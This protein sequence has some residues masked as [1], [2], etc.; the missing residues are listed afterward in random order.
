MTE[1]VE[2]SIVILLFLA[3]LHSVITPFPLL[4]S[5]SPTREAFVLKILTDPLSPTPPKIPFP[6]PCKLGAT[7]EI[8]DALIAAF[9]LEAVISPSTIKFRSILTLPPDTCNARLVL[10]IQLIPS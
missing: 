8:F 6:D 9:N 1:L 5:I 3:A 7:P 2:P 10:G 4:A